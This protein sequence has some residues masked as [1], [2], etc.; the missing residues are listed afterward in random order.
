MDIKSFILVMKNRFATILLTAVIMFGISAVAT[1]FFIK[2]TYEANEYLLIGSLKNEETVADTQRVN[3]MLASTMDLINSS[4]VLDQVQQT[5]EIDKEELLKSIAI[6]NNQNSQIINISVRNEDSEKASLIATTIAKTTV[7]QVN[8]LLNV[9]DVE[10]LN[11]AESDFE[12]VGSIQV[13]LAIGFAVGLLVGIGLAMLREYFDDTV[14][15]YHEIESDLGL[16]VLGEIT[17]NEKKYLRKVK[18]QSGKSEPIKE[19]GGN[20]SAQSN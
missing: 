1:L 16:S 18:R 13:N 12:K 11:K 20:I 8:E 15:N 17:I 6:K 10:V 3:R 7:R 19:N 2:P 14:R 9:N 5:M 4:V